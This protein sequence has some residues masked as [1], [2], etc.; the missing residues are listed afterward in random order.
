MEMKDKT[1]KIYEDKT[2]IV[3]DELVKHRHHYTLINKHKKFE[4]GHTHM[5]TIIL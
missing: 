2:F 4:N 3:L 1:R 5:M